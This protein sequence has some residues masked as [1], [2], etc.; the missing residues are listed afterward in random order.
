MYE[1]EKFKQKHEVCCSVLVLRKVLPVFSGEVL[2]LRVF[3]LDDEV[4]VDQDAEDS[5]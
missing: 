1:C 4:D 3:R 5:L 2:L